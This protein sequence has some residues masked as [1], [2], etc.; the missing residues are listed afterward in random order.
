M[1]PFECSNGDLCFRW[2]SLELLKEEEF[3]FPADKKVAAMLKE[4]NQK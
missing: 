3:T 4:E 2:L 1:N